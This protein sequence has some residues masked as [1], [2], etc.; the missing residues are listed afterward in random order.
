MRGRL[1]RPLRGAPAALKRSG[2]R[3]RPQRTRR[4]DRQGRGY[5]NEPRRREAL[6]TGSPHPFLQLGS[7]AT[8]ARAPVGLTPPHRPS[9]R[10]GPYTLWLS[11]TPGVRVC[12]PG[13]AISRSPLEDVP[14]D[15]ILKQLFL[16]R[17][18]LAR[19]CKWSLAFSVTVMR[20]A[21]PLIYRLMQSMAACLS[22]RRHHAGQKKTR[23]N[24][25]H[26]YPSARNADDLIHDLLAPQATPASMI[27]RLG[28]ILVKIAID[29]R[30][31]HAEV[32]QV[33]R[34]H[35]FIGQIGPTDCRLRTA[36]GSR[37]HDRVPD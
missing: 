7:A 25:G 30:H 36:T 21:R 24:C 6:E 28:Q 17:T 5:D 14:L 33:E 18:R 3:F 2:R 9:H 13:A 11:S 20:S 34:E 29:E 22:P 32:V 16:G 19:R 23:P 15:V 26:T 4:A 8:K 12:E 27:I 31:A 10:R 1:D 37:A 35:C